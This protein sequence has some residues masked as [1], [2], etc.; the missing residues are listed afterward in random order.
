MS[1][2]LDQSTRVDTRTFSRD[3]YWIGRGANYI[4]EKRLHDPW[5]RAQEQFLLELVEAENP[6]SILELGCGFGRV[7]RVLLD[8]LPDV[9][10]H[11]YDLSPDQ[12]ENARTYCV[13]RRV[14]FFCEDVRTM[15]VL[16]ALEMCLAVEFFLHLPDAELIPLVQR[17]MATCPV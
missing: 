8:A 3:Q 12:I 17:V 4:R 2:S 9:R 7:T 14:R 1:D 5:F 11:A 13:G 6:S 15:E 10:M 16:P